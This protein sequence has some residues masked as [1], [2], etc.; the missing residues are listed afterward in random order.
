MGGGVLEPIPALARVLT[1]NPKHQLTIKTS[2]AKKSYP[3]NKPIK[4]Y[5]FSKVKEGYLYV[6]EEKRDSFTFL[7]Q[8]DLEDCRSVE[9]K[10][11]CKVDNIWASKPLGKSVIYAVITKQPLEIESKRINKENL[12]INKIDGVSLKLNVTEK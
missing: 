8:Q 1:E 2:N 11:F 4:L 6:F 3:L 10:K 9:N 12:K 7:D 5:I